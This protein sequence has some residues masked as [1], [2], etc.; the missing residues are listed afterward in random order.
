M[1]AMEI[2]EARHSV[3][4]YLDIKIPQEKRKILDKNCSEINANS[5]LNIQ[6]LYDEP[7][8]FDSLL[9][10]YGR[11][12][13][14]R[15]Y[16]AIIGPEGD[17]LDEKAGYYGQQLVL[18]AQ[19][20]GL[21]TCWVAITHGKSQAKIGPGEKQAILI[22]LGYGVNQGIP[23]KNRNMKSAIVLSEDDPHWYKEGVKAALLA[24]TALNQQKFFIARKGELAKITVPLGM[25]TQIDLGI[26]KYNFEYATGH[27]TT[28]ECI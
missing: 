28:S 14:V 22:S 6:I 10:F 19:E 4:R 7:R 13:G 15:N 1:T 2:I 25:F 24:P 20:I 5:G 26:V 11:F 9:A 18:T 21:N 23:H 17:A 16:I 12:E 8:C 27:A 3:R